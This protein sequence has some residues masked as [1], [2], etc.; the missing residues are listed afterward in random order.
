MCASGYGSSRCLAQTQLISAL[1]VAPSC[2][3]LV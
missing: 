1:E 3:M 2:E